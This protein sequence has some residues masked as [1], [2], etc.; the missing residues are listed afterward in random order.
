MKSR[1]R[2]QQGLDIMNIQGR[3]ATGGSTNNTTNST[4]TTGKGI[5]AS[6][7]IDTSIMRPSGDHDYFLSASFLAAAPLP[8][9]DLALLS[10]EIPADG[11]IFA[12]LRSNINTLVVFRT[13]EERLNIHY[14][15]M[16]RTNWFVL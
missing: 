12:R 16:I 10:D 11:V 5:L 2:A 3:S 1:A 15:R 14:T 7:K 4:T 6:G 8:R 13:P 9:S